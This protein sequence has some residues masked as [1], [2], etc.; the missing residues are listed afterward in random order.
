MKAKLNRIRLRDVALFA[1]VAG[2]VAVVVVLAGREAGVGEQAEAGVDAA[3]VE[4]QAAAQ[5][6]DEDEAGS[7]EP[8]TL[9]LI[10]Q[11]DI[12]ETQAA[13]EMIFLGLRTNHRGERVNHRISQ[14]WSVRSETP[15]RWR[16][17]GG[18]GPYTLIIDGESRDRLSVYEGPL[19]RALVGC[20]DASVGTS[21]DDIGDGVQRLY[22]ADPQ[23]DSG[24]RT[25][26]AT[27]TDGAGSTAEATVDVYVIAEAPPLGVSEPLTPGQTYR[28]YGHLV[29]IPD[30]LSFLLG[31]WEVNECPA[32]QSAS[33]CE[34]SW[35]LIA[36]GDD[37]WLTIAFG[38]E[39]GD[40]INPLV[41]VD[42]ST[43]G[44]QGAADRRRALGLTLDTLA[45]SVGN[46]PD[47][48]SED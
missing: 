28:I 8:L 22:D 4:A 24:P 23:A 16:V 42:D 17:T 38:L 5:E 2:V 9:T 3:V 26:G 7:V 39:S 48:E 43:L 40:E 27:V 20:A 11:E 1:V 45:D 36:S 31:D 41:D 10:A 15:V 13:R 34:T 21:F 35:S 30:G 33:A 32:S 18:A 46:F 14:G 47:Q 25:I 19:G 6:G 44:A 37:Y 12:C 29:T